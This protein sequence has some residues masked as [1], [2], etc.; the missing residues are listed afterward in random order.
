MECM[1]K[2]AGDI[3]PECEAR[4]EVQAKMLDDASKNKIDTLFSG[5]RACNSTRCLL[6]CFKESIDKRCQTGQTRMLDTLVKEVMRDYG[7][8]KGWED[9]INYIMPES[10]KEKAYENKQPVQIEDSPSDLPNSVKKVNKSERKKKNFVKSKADQNAGKESLEKPSKKVAEDNVVKETTVIVD[11]EIRT[12]RYELFDWLGHPVQSPDFETLARIITQKLLPS[13]EKT[14]HPKS[15]SVRK[16][17]SKYGIYFQQNKISGNSRVEDLPKNGKSPEWLP[18]ERP[19]IIF[20]EVETVKEGVSV[21]IGL[22]IFVATVL[23]WLWETA[24]DIN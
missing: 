15:I 3:Q 20:R 14:E 18:E 13:S 16:H 7:E 8:G 6:T 5:P 9:A 4:C 10:C 21:T 12:L 1:K 23:Y 11:G 2:T 17:P 24:R 22:A 19:E